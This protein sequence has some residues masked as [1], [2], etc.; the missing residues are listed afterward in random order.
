MDSS[1]DKMISEIQ[2]LTTEIKKLETALD[3]EK[4]ADRAMRELRMIADA[5]PMVQ[6]CGDDY[7]ELL[8]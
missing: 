3:Y 1:I 2:R 7:E 6:R 8:E 4:L 5:V